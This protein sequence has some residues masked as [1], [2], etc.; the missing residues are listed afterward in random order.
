[1]KTTRNGRD[2]LFG[3][4]LAAAGLFTAVIVLADHAG[5]WLV[6]NGI[7]PDDAFR[8]PNEPRSAL[9][10]PAL[11]QASRAQQIEAYAN[12]P[13]SFEP[14]QGQADRAVRFLARGIGYSLFLTSTD[15]ELILNRATFVLRVLRRSSG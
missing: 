10:Q 1:M 3:L 14:N 11:A 9:P 6:P 5:P 7:Q 13:V 8:Q 15:A 2:V 4:M 12:L